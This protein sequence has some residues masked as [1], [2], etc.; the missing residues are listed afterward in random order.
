MKQEQTWPKNKH[1][2]RTNMEQEQTCNKVK[3]GTRT[4]IEQKTNIEHEHT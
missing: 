2:T 1:E 4:E 3:H